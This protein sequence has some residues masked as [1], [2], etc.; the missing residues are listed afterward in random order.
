[1]EQEEGPVTRDEAIEVLGILLAYYPK[2]NVPRETLE[3]WVM[4]IEEF[5]VESAQRVVLTLGHTSKWLPSLAEVR[6]LC[7]QDRDGSLNPQ[8][9]ESAIKLLIQRNGRSKPALSDPYSDV[10]DQVPGGWWA[11][12][13]MDD[14]SF[15]WAIK[16]AV[17]S[18]TQP[19]LD[20]PDPVPLTKDSQLLALVEEV[21]DAHT[22]D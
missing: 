12:C 16:E 2:E 18:L 11:L 5:P 14:K 20:P 17:A 6:E 1:M 22:L 9:M 15:H 21:G 3:L 8:Q 10:V 7:I 19:H 4:G 13:E